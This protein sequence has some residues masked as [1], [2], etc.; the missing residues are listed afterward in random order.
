MPIF[1][2]NYLNLEYFFNLVYR[3]LVGI[4]PFLV[5]L[6]SSLTALKVWLIALSLILAAA[7]VILIYK[8]TNLRKEEV[9]GFLNLVRTDSSDKTIRD[10]RWAKL[11]KVMDSD[12][13]SD[14]KQAIIEADIMLDEMVQAMNYPG[15][16]LGERLKAI[17]PS[18]FLSLQDAWEA[19]KTRNQIAHDSQFVLTRREARAALDR[20][21]RVFRE[22]NFI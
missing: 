19:H 11:I 3:F 20:F 6:F 14:W 13:P 15:E 7:I 22:F 2:P 4:L 16:N 17:E 5:A 1:E 21:E 9:R 12:N 10:E 8:I 18:D